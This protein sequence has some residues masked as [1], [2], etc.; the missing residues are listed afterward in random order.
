MKLRSH[1]I[2]VSNQGERDKQTSSF[3][4]FRK[5]LFKNK[6]LSTPKQTNQRHI[7]KK[8]PDYFRKSILRFLVESSTNVNPKVSSTNENLILYK[9]N[10]EIDLPLS[11]IV[12]RAPLM[13]MQAL[14]K[15][16]I[17]R[18]T[19]S[20]HTRSIT[21]V[22]RQPIIEIQSLDDTALDSNN[23]DMTV[24]EIGKYDDHQLESMTKKRI[25]SWARKNELQVAI[26]NQM[27]FQR[28]PSKIFGKRSNSHLKNMFD[29]LLP[30]INDKK[31]SNDTII[32]MTKL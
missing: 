21:K 5:N 8:I 18:R 7:H 26:V 29:S 15:Q 31:T 9:N 12:R 22:E 27:Y 10:K 19:N 24:L 3:K 32:T 6:K 11:K 17:L 20:V 13:G 2:L 16:K 25:P 4:T 14:N 30:N 28:N 1:E 23:Y